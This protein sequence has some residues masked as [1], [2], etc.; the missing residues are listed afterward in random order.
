MFPLRDTSAH[1][2]RALCTVGDLLVPAGGLAFITI[3]MVITAACSAEGP[4][5]Y[6]HSEP[7]SSPL[8]EPPSKAATAPSAPLPANP[9]GSHGLSASAARRDTRARRWCGG[10]AGRAG[11]PRETQA[12]ISSSPAPRQPPTGWAVGEDAAA[13]RT[14]VSSPIPT[15]AEAGWERSGSWGAVSRG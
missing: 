5:A 15:L 9:S 7:G 11:S 10:W 8:A 12:G 13:K 3:V 14:A 6:L 1:T 4:E 2:M